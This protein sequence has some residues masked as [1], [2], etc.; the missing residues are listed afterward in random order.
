MKKAVI[1]ISFLLL[2]VN[3]SAIEGADFKKYQNQS[4]GV[5]FNYPNTLAIDKKNSRKDPLSV[6]FNYGQPPFAVSILF[7]EVMDS[8]NLEEFIRNERKNQEASGYRAQIE[9]NKYTIDGKIPTIEFIRTS[10]IGTIYYYIFPSQKL[11]KLF[12]FWHMTN[13]IVDPD[14]KAVESYRIMRESLKISNQ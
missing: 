13:K 1:S 2:A 10:E 11:E 4:L 7:K 12:A 5:T 14:E 9:E 6:V 3:F 8:N